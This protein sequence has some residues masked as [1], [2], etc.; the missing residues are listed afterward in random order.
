MKLIS[1]LFNRKLHKYLRNI[2]I[3]MANSKDI[4]TP[5][6]LIT[7]AY[8]PDSHVQ[9]GFTKVEMGIFIKQRTNTLNC[10]KLK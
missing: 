10:N 5:Y 4:T 1:M 6:S 8:V 3:I 9:Q 7:G 2:S